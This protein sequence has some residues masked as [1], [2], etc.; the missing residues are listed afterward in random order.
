M[1]LTYFGTAAAEG[2]PAVFCRC[3]HCLEAR[4]L[5]GKNVRTRSQAM[6]GEDLLI[7]FPADTY[8]H[9]LQNGVEGDRIRYLLVTHPHS[10]H[11]C[12]S[13]LGMRF[14]AYAHEMR[15]ETLRILCPEA[16]ATAI[17]RAPLGTEVTVLRAFETV[18]LGEYRVTPLPARHMGAEESF[19]YL[20]EGDRTLLYAHDTGYF[21]EEVFAYLEE[22]RIRLDAISLDCTNGTT[23]VSDEG[24]HMGFA[25]IERVLSRLASFGAVTDTTARIVNHFSH[26]VAPL[27]HLLEEKAAPLGCLVAYDGYRVEL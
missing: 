6:I 10:D 9:F 15:E 23:T 24:R 5:G 11:L 4:R 21:F 22:Q 14:G 1:K 17:G 3:R 13:D 12:T 7:D 19:I 26:N 18:E 27:Q 20:I 8:M 25:N 16:V 2:F